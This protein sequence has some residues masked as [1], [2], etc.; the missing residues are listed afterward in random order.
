[1]KVGKL[2]QDSFIS[3]PGQ[4]NR[5]KTWCAR[6]IPFKSQAHDHRF[7]IYDSI[8]RDLNYFRN[9]IINLGEL[10]QIIE[11]WEGLSN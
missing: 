10:E 2:G 1:M 7:N 5:S 8:H 9:L 4:F 6:N 11:L 3:L